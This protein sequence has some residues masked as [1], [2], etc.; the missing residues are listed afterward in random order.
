M[1]VERGIELGLEAADSVLD[2]TIST[3]R[4]RRSGQRARNRHPR[5][6]GLTSR[7]M[8]RFIT[9]VAEEAPLCGVEVVEVS[10]LYDSGDI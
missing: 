9:L 8:L 7:E 2:R 3:F 1:T 4:R 10:P 6:G 5:A